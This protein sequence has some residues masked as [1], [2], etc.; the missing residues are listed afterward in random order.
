MSLVS[1]VVRRLRG[2]IRTLALKPVRA[3]R[4]GVYTA[5]SVRR[6]ELSPTEPLKT[7]GATLGA[8]VVVLAL[9]FPVYWI[10]TAALSSTGGSIYSSGGLQLLPENPTVQPFLWVIGDLVVPAYTVSLN[11][12]LSDLAI[13]LD[14]PE[15]VMLDVSQY[16]VENPSE[17]KRFLWN[18]LTVAVPTVII[19]MCLVVPAAYALS[20][21][22]F[23]LRRK[24][25]FVYVLMTQ[26]GGGLGVALLI[27]LYAVY[28]QFGINDSKLALAVYYAA[29]AV[30]FNTWLLKTYM[31]GIPV[32]YEEAAVVDGAPPW[33][34]VTEVI[35]PLSTAGLATVFI[36]TFLTGWTEF[37]VAQTLLGTEN[38]TLPVGLYSLISEYSIPWAR[39][40]AFA[41]TFATPI[42]LVYL[43]AQRYIEGGL[44]FSGMEG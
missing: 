6:G 14:T 44:S 24:V 9:L 3:V 18:S 17:F 30:P 25:L 22:E 29:T 1:N 4:E 28:V 41:L 35:L 42:M 43:F 16:G 32:S 7:V 19:A 26:V 36:F 38:Y 5:N 27:G 31:D 34:V 20:R 8:L 2:D 39:F 13:V 23:V 11:V 33:R 10:L 21:R 40:S 15:I 12:P 37:V